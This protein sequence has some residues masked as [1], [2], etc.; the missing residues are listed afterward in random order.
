[1]LFPS[2]D[3]AVV[4]GVND[5]AAASGSYKPIFTADSTASASTIYIANANVSTTITKAS[6]NVIAIQMTS[7][8]ATG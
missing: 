5:D 3:T 8:S 1:M 7:G 6:L 2:H 4:V